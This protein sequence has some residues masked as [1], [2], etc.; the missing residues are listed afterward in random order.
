MQAMANE[1][2]MTDPETRQRFFRRIKILDKE[3]LAYINEEH[4]TKETK[5][6][7]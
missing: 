7:S 2:E 6:V 4:K 1:L 3:Y 5:N